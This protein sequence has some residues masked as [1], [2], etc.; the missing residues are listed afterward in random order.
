MF[1]KSFVVNVQKNIGLDINLPYENDVNNVNVNGVNINNI[2]L[3]N[4]NTV[5]NVNV[6]NDVDMIKLV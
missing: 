2:N 6:I 3:N 5:N 4:A 1:V